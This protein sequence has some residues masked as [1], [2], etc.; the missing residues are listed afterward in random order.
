M[1][2]R[3][4]EDMNSSIVIGCIVEFGQAVLFRPV[5]LEEACALCHTWASSRKPYAHAGTS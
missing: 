3:S 5:D 2:L 1:L 4:N